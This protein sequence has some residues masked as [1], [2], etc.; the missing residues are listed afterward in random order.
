MPDVN[1]VPLGRAGT[2]AAVILPES[3]AANLL[4]DN[5]AQ[6][7]QMAQYNRKLQQD[8]AAAM[9][10]SY[11]DNALK[12]QAGRL[13]NPEVQTLINNHVQQGIDYRKQGF[14]IYNP[15]PNDQNQLA[16]HEQYMLDRQKL[17]NL[18]NQQ[19]A[20]NTDFDSTMKLV[21]ANPDK[22]TPESIK[23]LNDFVANNKFQDVVS[24]GLRFPQLEETFDREK[25][26]ISKIHP[27]TIEQTVTD[28]DGNKTQVTKPVM[29]NI[30]YQAASTYAAN[31][32]ARKDLEKKMGLPMADLLHTTDPDEVRQALDDSYR[33]DP[34][35]LKLLPAAGIKSFDSPEYKTFLDNQVKH[36]I[37]AE[38]IYNNEIEDVTKKV[39]SK[40]DPKYA[41]S[42]DF[43]YNQ[44]KRA[45][46]DQKM[47]RGN[48]GM[49]VTR[50][51]D[52]KSNLE[53]KN[54]VMQN[55]DQ[56]IKG[57][58]SGSPEF[59]NYLKQSLAKT[60]NSDVF[61]NNK[62]NLVV[63]MTPKATSL[64]KKPTPVYRVIDTSDKNSNATVEINDLLNETT[65]NK[66]PFE[67][68][69]NKPEK[70]VSIYDIGDHGVDQQTFDLWKTTYKNNA[71]GLVDFLIN[72][73]KLVGT[74]S[75]AVKAANDILKGTT[76]KT[77]TL[78]Q[79]VK[80]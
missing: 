15:N 45:E 64:V 7:R 42:F 38:N 71:P 79:Q 56:W 54:L 19:K 27:S 57:I 44:E 55:R 37:N 63:K 34:D 52:W 21:D 68:L 50:F 61:Y 8:Q 18:T 23:S 74:Y 3:N 39:A 41:N 32:K 62:G 60:G 80:K 5:I 12:A 66:I 47:Q 14:D 69:Y 1:D 13:W 78:T 11:Q 76:G 40:V 75:E 59:V 48:Y 9:A 24:K 26:V 67:K 73:A 51:D 28:K 10:K 35:K 33:T 2:G 70:D 16:A 65:G 36:Q 77:K 17:L 29:A 20:Y 4:M 53:D 46:D 6:N 58:Q 30:Q 72:K 43:S 49:T 31:P 22:Y 25:D